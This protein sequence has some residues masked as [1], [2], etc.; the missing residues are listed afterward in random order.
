MARRS[1]VNYITIFSILTQ[2]V[3]KTFAYFRSTVILLPL[4]SINIIN[5]CV[6]QS[7]PTSGKVIQKINCV[8]IGGGNE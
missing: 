7:H 5:Q 2:F 6:F 1:L 4:H 3:L 8:L